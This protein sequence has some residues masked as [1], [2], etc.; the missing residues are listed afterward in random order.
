MPEIKE[1]PGGHPCS[2]ANIIGCNS[3][4]TECVN[5]LKMFSAQTKTAWRNSKLILGTLRASKTVRPETK[6]YI[7]KLF[8]LRMVLL[9]VSVGINIGLSYPQKWYST[10]LNERNEA[11]FWWYLALFIG[12][13]L[14]TTPL[15]A[16]E[17]FISDLLSMRFRQILTNMLFDIYM[18]KR[19]YYHIK[20]K[21]VCYPPSLCPQSIVMVAT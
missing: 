9:V 18:T 14:I 6:R 19:A 13:I 1:N 10:A 12:V 7:L 2:A 5:N 4:Y 15:S 21:I 20:Q 11:E 3:W 16:F 8:I 17:G